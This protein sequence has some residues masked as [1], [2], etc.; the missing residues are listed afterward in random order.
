MA[1]EVPVT[2]SDIASEARSGATTR[3]ANGV[4][5]DQKTAWD[6]ATTRR[7][8]TSSSK[9]GA[10]ADPTWPAQKTASTQTMSAFGETW[11]AASMSGSESSATAHA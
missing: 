2:M 7:E 3:T 8:A 9:L 6:A 11:L 1:T 5:T 10:T 4:A